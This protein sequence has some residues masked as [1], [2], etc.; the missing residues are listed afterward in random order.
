MAAVLFKR[1]LSMQV[2]V[3][4]DLYLGKEEPPLK[5]TGQAASGLVVE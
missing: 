1:Q 2:F 3:K 5:L 4:L